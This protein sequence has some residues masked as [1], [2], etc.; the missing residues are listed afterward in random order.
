VSLKTEESETTP[1]REGTKMASSTPPVA[2]PPA[3]PGAGTAAQKKGTSA[4]VW[5]LAGCGGLIIIIGLIFAGV[6]YWG[7]HKVKNYAEIAKKNPALAAAKLMV[8]ANPDVE[9]VSEDDNAGTITVRDKKTGEEITMN[10][11]DIKN[12]RLKFTNKKGEEV[13]FQGSGKPGQEGFK[14][15]SNKGSMTFGGGEAEPAPA[16]VPAY[17]GGK[18]MATSREKTAEGFTGTLSFQ[19][20]DAVD[21]VTAQYEKELKAKGFEVNRMAMGAMSSLNAKGDG[22][23]HTVNVTVIRVGDATQVTVE[24]GS[25]AGESK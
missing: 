13:T 11:Q 12:G 23:R 25:T 1:V 8:A 5:I 16:W 19:T 21:V 22:G 14:I 9:I 2:P 3:Q 7:Y 4:L 15:E 20:A 24:Y 18:T 6:T 10:A 17:P